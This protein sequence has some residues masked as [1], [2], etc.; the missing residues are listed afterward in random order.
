MMTNNRINNKKTLIVINIVAILIIFLLSLFRNEFN[1]D[2]IILFIFI[3][4]MISV[5]QYKPNV[6]IKYLFSIFGSV[7]MLVG[8][9][10]CNTDN[11]YLSE[12]ATYSKYNGSLPIAIL[13]FILYFAFLLIFD[14]FFSKKI[15]Y[16]SRS[17]ETRFNSIYNYFIN[18]IVFVIALVMLLGVIKHP[19]FLLDI[20]RFVY[21][22]TYLPTWAN[23]LQTILLYIM[24]TILFSII[25]K[26]D[27]LSA[28]D[29]KKIIL[30]VLPFI[31][32]GFWTG[33]KFGLFFNIFILI[34]SPLIVYLGKGKLK[35]DKLDDLTLNDN[36]EMN[37]KKKTKK[38][39]FSSFVVLLL[40]IVPY[41][42]LRG[43]KAGNSLFN[44]TAQQG[45]L[46]WATYEHEKGIGFHTNEISDEITPLFNNN[47]DSIN[48]SYGIYKIMQITTPYSLYIDKINTGSRYSAQG[49][50]IAFY[51][52]KYVGLIIHAIIRAFVE[53]LL[54]NLLIKFVFS[55]RM[56]ETLIIARIILIAHTVFTQGDLYLFFA[57]DTI[58]LLIILIFLELLYRK[59]HK[60]VFY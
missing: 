37:L 58:V 14:T 25:Y 55:R 27:K 5:F 57:Y 40:I 49:L 35:Q 7:F 47:E 43:L 36:N 54:V 3:F 31:V 6:F 29:I 22:T 45:Q 30:T 24:P 34:L 46:W 19:S 17:K 16:F 13:Y 33:N 4:M 56:L 39:L 60:N 42:S 20:D 32:Y 2:L 52:F 23:K 11:V 26:N 9:A 21:E 50:E 12:L 38:I 8:L 10:I 51:Y 48:K 44:R 41:Y 53:A 1:A 28:N 15:K 59:N 18:G